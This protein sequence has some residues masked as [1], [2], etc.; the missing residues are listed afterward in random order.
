MSKGAVIVHGSAPPLPGETQA[1]QAFTESGIPKPA[2]KRRKLTDE[3]K[4]GRDRLKAEAREERARQ[5]DERRAREKAQAKLDKIAEA[6]GGKCELP[7][8]VLRDGTVRHVPLADALDAASLYLGALCLDVE[9]S[10]YWIGHRHYQLRT[11]QL[12]GEEMAVVLDAA[13]PAQ[14][15]VASWALKGARKLHAHS[16]TA[17]LAPCVHAGLIGWDEGWAKM[18]DSVLYAKLSDPRLT[19]SE[20][21]GLK[22]LAADLLHEY[23]T[24]PAAEAAKNAL[25]K[26]LGCKVKT[27]STDPPE[28]NGWYQVDKRAVTMIR[29]AGSDVLDLAAVLRTLPELPV[30]EAVL[31]RE[32]RVQAQCARLALEGANLDKPHVKKLIGEHEASRVMHRENVLKLSDGRITNPSS[33][34]VGAALL[35]IDPSLAGVL[36]LSAKTGKPSAAKA[37]LARI[38]DVELSELGWPTQ[39][40]V[41]NHQQQNPVSYH[42]AREILAYRHDV[43]TLGLLLRPLENL[44]DHGDGKMRPVVYTISADTGRMSTVRP[45]SQQFSKK[46][47]VRACVQAPPGY[48]GISADFTGCEIRVAAAL[49]GDRKLLEAETSPF[50]Y[51]CER[52][53]FLEDPCPCGV[54]TEGGVTEVAG[55]TGLHWLAAHLTFGKDAVKGDRYAAKAVIFRK[56]FGGAPDSEVAAKIANV[57]DTRIAPQYAAWDAWLRQCW[58]SGSKV[59]R[60]Y[61][62][63]QNFATDLPGRSRY[64]IYQTYSGR[65]IYATKGAHA[66]G[67]YAIQGTARELLVDGLL[68]WADGPYRDAVIIPVHDELIGFVRE[69]VAKEATR[70]LVE[71]MATDVLSVP[72]WRVA[73]GAD[74]DEPWTSW[75]DAA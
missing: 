1:I 63:G 46:G 21:N 4:A 23:A 67:N 70:S 17:D 61:A 14:M 25:F 16:A 31:T 50:C 71:C 54:K 24:A 43:T 10:G 58:Y 49:A 39:Y 40:E 6:E 57:F 73:V 32:R 75:P 35:E 19:G 60:D 64:A 13:D 8:V 15:A 28:E 48:R 30:A 34:D 59:Y 53:S 66:V 72:G 22:D 29:Y 41:N 7:A 12:G 11:V 2:Q 37:S 65:Q 69:D 26:A 56:L 38:R 62:T 9:T 36:E 45:N 68:R 33:P 47:G 27:E 5:R 52:D 55:H 20:A 42:L 3:E 74:A 44:C 51:K 18:H